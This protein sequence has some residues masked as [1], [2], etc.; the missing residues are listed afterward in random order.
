MRLTVLYDIK[1]ALQAA[2]DMIIISGVYDSFII[3][4]FI[5]MSI[6]VNI[7]RLSLSTPIGFSEKLHGGK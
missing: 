4:V 7:T 3:Y 2:F 5:F 1:D 6:P